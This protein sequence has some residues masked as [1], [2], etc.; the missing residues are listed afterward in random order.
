M[1]AGSEVAS[2]ELFYKAVNRGRAPFPWQDRLAAKVSEEGWPAEI[3]IPTGLGK[4]TCLDIALWALARQSALP[5][6]E[7]TAPTRIWYVVNRRLLVDAAYD[8]GVRL[9]R[10]LQNPESLRS[11]GRSDSELQAA[12]SVANALNS[13]GG[14]IGSGPLQVTRLRGGAELGARPSHP[15]QPSL[16]FST[17]PMF[18]SRWLFRGYGCSASMRPV[19]AALAGVDS[20]V[21]LDE[22]HLAPALAGLSTPLGQCDIG[23][24]QRLLNGARSRPVLVSLTATGDAASP[25]VLDSADMQHPT[26][27][28]RLNAA[29]P[30]RLVPSRE[31]VLVDD[32]CAELAYNLVRQ[33]SPAAAVVFVNS[34]RTARA[35]F[36]RLTASR[37]KL[38]G[39]LAD[40]ELLTGRIR[41]REGDYIRHRLLDPV[42][43]APAGRNR[44]GLTRHLVV[45]ATQTLEVG[46]DLDFDVLVSEACGT[47]SL[48]QRLGRLNRLGDTAGAAGSLVFAQDAKEFG[49]YGE[50]PRAVWEQLLTAAVD[51]VVDLGPGRIADVVGPP[52]DLP[53]QTGELLHAHLWEWAKT[54]KPA[55]DEAPPELFFDGLEPKRASVSVAWR[56][57]EP[58]PGERL[59]PSMSADES[60]EIPLGEFRVFAE[61]QS[62][63]LTRLAS[64]RVTMEGPLLPGRIRPGDQIVLPSFAGGHDEFGWA[65]T[66]REPV[67]DVSLWR[68]PGI[69]MVADAF[70]MLINEGDK[71]EAVVRLS[72][73]LADPPEP[74]ETIDRSRLETEL[75]ESFRSAE[76]TNS[77]FEEEWGSLIERVRPSVLYPLE[78][79]S[80]LQVRAVADGRS[81]P[82]LRADLFDDLSFSATSAL[83]GE[84]NG[85]VS[86]FA[87]R[88]AERVGLPEIMSTTLALAGRFHDLGKCDV[89]FQRWLD[90]GAESAEPI[91][92]SSRPWQ[93]WQSDRV[94]SGWPK[95]GRHEDLS[96]RLVEA[97]LETAGADPTIQGDLLLHLIASHHGQGRPLLRPVRDPFATLVSAEVDGVLLK[98]S[99]DLSEVDW[100]QPARFRRC[101]ETY[102]YWG[103]ALLE[104]I[105]RQADHEVSRVVVA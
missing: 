6:S 71:L 64:D 1:I 37:E 9:Q 48:V 7:R 22:A 23:R 45:V 80:W 75:L 61:E 41:D 63:Q 43:G 76:P 54:T 95:G 66:C 101:C 15:A 51:G 77:I 81:I 29:K 70:R 3:G 11:E 38:L 72:R 85:S 62:L 79:P 30:M 2:F 82:M 53:P 59:V 33:D 14:R 87:A 56:V 98:A 21:L 25:F 42:T 24:P 68:F 73:Q 94:P 35:V 31:K 10:V 39:Q 47:R 99:A 91:A 36:E 57:V 93:Y 8:L 83:V 27:Q 90:P 13:I 96:R 65:P 78:G 88:I 74:D 100:E 55:P 89:R 40:L 16:I 26:V 92:K 49:I 97:W 84:H 105:L 18:A 19:E 69:P 46:A 5:P 17:V 60:V 32:L 44:S 86:E 102:G 12:A 103:L 20:L 67:L 104:A 52:T 34:P 4:T 58:K 50:Q 28:R